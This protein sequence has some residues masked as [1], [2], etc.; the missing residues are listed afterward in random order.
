MQD[1][2]DFSTLFMVYQISD[3]TAF[4]SHQEVMTVLIRA[5]IRAKLPL[6]F[7]QGFNPHP[8]FSLPLPKNVGV[9][10]LCELC[11][12]QL[13]RPASQIDSVLIRKK[14]NEQ[15][16]EGISVISAEQYSG[17][18]GCQVSDVTYLIRCSGEEA[19]AVKSDITEKIESKDF[20]FTR[21]KHKTGKI[22]V[23]P[24]AQLIERLKPEENGLKL[25]VNFSSSGTLKAGEILKLAG[26][27]D[28]DLSRIV[29]INIGWA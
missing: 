17:K 19:E 23:L 12:V 26:Y 4:L 22:K 29:R 5:C 10:S 25:K 2:E 7:S 15:L 24:L 18:K 20:Q 27:D 14:L 28:T 1:G 21:K 11:V 13:E 6:R 16:P 9:E 8:R 3:G